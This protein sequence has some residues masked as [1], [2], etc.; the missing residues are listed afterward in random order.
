MS[1]VRERELLSAAGQLSSA[2]DSLRAAGF[3]T[4]ADEID[5][6]IAMLDVEIL[7]STVPTIQGS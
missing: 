5:A 3:G 4:M 6:L 2:A 7:L 1:V